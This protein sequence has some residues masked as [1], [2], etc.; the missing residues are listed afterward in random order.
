METPIAAT[1]AKESPLPSLYEERERLAKEYTMFQKNVKLIIAEKFHSPLFLVLTILMTAIAAVSAVL[2]A[3]SLTQKGGSLVWNLLLSAPV[4]ACAIA[5]ACAL[6]KTYTAKNELTAEKLKGVNAYT[7]YM[8]IIGVLSCILAGFVAILLVI[9][10]TTVSEAG[11]STSELYNILQQAAQEENLPDLA[12]AISEGSTVITVLLLLAAALLMAFFICYTMTFSK[13]TKHFNFLRNAIA[14]E[15]YNTAQKS[16]IV[17]AIL[18]GTL[19]SIFGILTILISWQIGLLFLLTG[20]F[21]ILVA[22]LFKNIS[23]CEATNGL[24]LQKVV[25]ALQDINTAI[26]QE[27]RRQKELEEQD[28]KRRLEE[29]K[30][31]QA[32]QQQL[33]QAMMMQMMNAQSSPTNTLSKAEQSAPTDKNDDPNKP[34]E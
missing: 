27:E 22:I 14:S 31:E 28:R 7:I 8:T 10:A 15:K 25:A 29:E 2:M 17:L 34:R 13:T 11:Q 24:H 12:N 19:T 32:K 5:S 18:F 4:V 26:N 21:L 20:P 30:I 16:P 23:V 6:W 9:L 33:M 1:M 3:L